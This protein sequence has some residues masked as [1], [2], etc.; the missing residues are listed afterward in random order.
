M[1]SSPTQRRLPLARCNTGLDVPLFS[2]TQFI[3]VFAQPFLRF[4]QSCATQQ[5][6]FIT[7]LLL[8]FLHRQSQPVLPDPKLPILFDP[9][10]Q[11]LPVSQQGFVNHFDSFLTLGI[12]PGDH[13]PF[14]RQ[15]RDQIPVSRSHLFTGRDLAGILGALAGPHQLY[16][17]SPQPFPFVLKSNQ[18]FIGMTR[19]SLRH[20]TDG[21]IGGM[22]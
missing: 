3:R 8:P 14:I 1:P 11:R 20:A 7:A 10:A 22:G 15:F 19:Q 21:L 4:R 16:K 18:G 13:Q 12:T 2:L 6:P 17:H 9:L 5:R